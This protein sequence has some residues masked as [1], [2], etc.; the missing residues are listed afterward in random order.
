MALLAIASLPVFKLT[1][2][3][4]GYYEKHPFFFLFCTIGGV[5]VVVDMV[6]VGLISSS[7]SSIELLP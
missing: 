1:D 2:L 6:G 4:G 7:I 3:E 5:V